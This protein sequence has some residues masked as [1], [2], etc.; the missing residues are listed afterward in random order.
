MIPDA[1]APWES[2][3]DVL[4]PLASRQPHPSYG[5]PARIA[6]AL[7]IMIEGPLGGAAFNNEFGRPNLLGYFRTYQQ[8]VWAALTL[9]TPTSM[10][11]LWVRS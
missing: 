8:N 7:D 9:P 5:A 3:Q 10:R 6:S 11:C 4:A 2:A 1:V